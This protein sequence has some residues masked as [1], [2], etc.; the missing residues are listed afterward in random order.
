MTNWL[1]QDTDLF[2]LKATLLS[3]LDTIAEVYVA[4][5]QEYA[6]PINPSRN[7]ALSYYLYR[8]YILFE[9]LFLRIVEYFGIEIADQSQWHAELLRNMAAD[10]LPL[11]PAVIS[12]ESLAYLN[13]LRGFRHFFRSGRVLHFDLAEF[14]LPYNAACQL[15]PLYPVEIN[16]FLT[17]LDTLMSTK[18]KRKRK[19]AIKIDF[20]RDDFPFQP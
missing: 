13:K 11:R 19:P 18:K 7:I 15:K 2:L 5:E 3:D 6:A 10:L 1:E 9:T 20:A 12:S 17:F 4:L 8:L 16:N 14:R